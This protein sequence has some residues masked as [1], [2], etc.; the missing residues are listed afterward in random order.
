MNRNILITGGFSEKGCELIDYLL[1]NTNHFVINVDS[2][3]NNSEKNDEWKTYKNYLS[4]RTSLINIECLEFMIFNYSVDTMVHF[5]Y[6][7]SFT[8]FPRLLYEN[9][10]ATSI[11][12]D[13]CT[14]YNVDHF[15]TLSEEVESN[16]IV[17]PIMEVKSQLTSLFSYFKN[18]H[19][20]TIVLLKNM[21]EIKRLT[22]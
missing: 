9:V 6:D 13:L 8:E 14:K 15:Y 4:I 12:L 17:N 1:S 18:V 19:K 21:E 16:N 10:F 5:A 7:Y 2:F 20:K 11:L 3:Q 22:N